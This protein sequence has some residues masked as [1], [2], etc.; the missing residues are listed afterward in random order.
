M[1]KTINLEIGCGE[2]KPC[3][4]DF[5]GLD[6]FPLPGVDIVC[7]LDTRPIPLPDNHCDLVYASHVLEHV[8][9]LLAVM[10]EIWRVCKP[11][12]QLCILAPY[13]SNTVNFANPYHFQNFNE[14]TPRF[15]TSSPTSL[16][17][18]A[19]YVDPFVWGA[20]WGLGQSDNSKSDMDFRCLRIEFFY[21]PAYVNKSVGTRRRLRRSQ[22]NVCHSLLY[23]LVAFKPPMQE[24][25]LEKMEVDYYIPQEVEEIREALG[26]VL[27]P[28]RF[29]RWIRSALRRLGMLK[30]VV[31]H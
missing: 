9:N 30:K 26:T 14:H 17:D 10:R 28:K 1:A 22:N 19:E 11:G 27:F 18:P 12:A 3:R 23:H 7:D 15:W 29:L 24:P 2:R 20:R 5:I 16:I 8:S 4:A 6:R 21:Y 25:D 13:Y 31:S